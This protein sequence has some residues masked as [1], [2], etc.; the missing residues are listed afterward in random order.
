MIEKEWRIGLDRRRERDRE[1]GIEE[2]GEAVGGK[3]E[4]QETERGGW[5]S[6]LASKVTGTLFLMTTIS[7]LSSVSVRLDIKQDNPLIPLYKNQEHI[8]ATKPQKRGKTYT[9][10]KNV[11]FLTRLKFEFS[12]NSCS[13][14][15][16]ITIHL[17]KSG[18][19][20]SANVITSIK[21]F[22]LWA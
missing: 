16:F 11:F 2:S 8:P 14:I 20:W 3:E 17:C 12:L 18:L 10:D 5:I 13:K 6:K 22:L 9:E 4:R 21:Q 7:P 15:L 19:W 1:E